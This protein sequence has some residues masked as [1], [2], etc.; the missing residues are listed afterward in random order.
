MDGIVDQNEVV[1][2]WFVVGYVC[3]CGKFYTIPTPEIC[4]GC[5]KPRHQF[6]R[7]SILNKKIKTFTKNLFTGVFEYR[8]EQEIGEPIEEEDEKEETTPSVKILKKL[9]E[10]IQIQTKTF[11]LL[12]ELLSEIKNK[13]LTE[14]DI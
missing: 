14:D 5:G 8:Y 7:Y 3:S 2:Q 10:L 4:R 12:E 9:D 13:T 1:D 11:N 6:Q